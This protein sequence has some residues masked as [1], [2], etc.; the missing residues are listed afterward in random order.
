MTSNDLKMTS[1][2][3]NDKAVFKKLKPKKNLK[4]IDPNHVNP[5]IGRNFIGKGFSPQ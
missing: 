1:E 3:G 5:N 2:D 4:G